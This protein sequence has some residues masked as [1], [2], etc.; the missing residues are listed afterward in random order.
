MRQSLGWAA[1]GALHGQ[2]LSR[3]RRRRRVALP[4]ASAASAATALLS[5]TQLRWLC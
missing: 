3:H 1:S 4:A 5:C 2:V